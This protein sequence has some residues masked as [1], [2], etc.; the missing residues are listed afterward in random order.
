MTSKKVDQLL[1]CI[2]YIYYMVCLK[3][4]QAKIQILIDFK[5][6]IHIIN[7]AYTLKINLKIW[8]TN[9]KAYKIDNFTFEVFK[10]AP[11]SFQ[12]D[13]KLGKS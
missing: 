8:S 5:N 10:I 13:N 9:I 2:L 4:N 1:K 7:P 3:K 11:T 12:I 6:N